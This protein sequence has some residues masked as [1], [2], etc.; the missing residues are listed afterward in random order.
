[1]C[2]VLDFVTFYI[3]EEVLP[4]LFLLPGRVSFCVFRT[5]HVRQSAQ[6]RRYAGFRGS[7]FLFYISPK[8]KRSEKKEAVIKRWDIKGKITQKQSHFFGKNRCFLLFIYGV[9]TGIMSGNAES[10]FFL[11]FYKIFFNFLYIFRFHYIMYMKGSFW[12][13]FP[14]S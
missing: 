3:W 9:F 5:V 11:F 10:L 2:I 6:T 8:E 1:M 7:N 4:G 13:L 12:E 14:F